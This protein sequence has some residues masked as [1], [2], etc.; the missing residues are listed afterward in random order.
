MIQSEHLKHDD[1]NRKSARASQ[2]QDDISVGS[3]QFYR[4]VFSLSISPQRFPRH[5]PNFSQL[6]QKVRV[7]QIE[8]LTP[9]TTNV[10]GTLVPINYK[11]VR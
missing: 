7:R 10:G 8:L 2:H 3:E 5:S 4:H 9:A 6:I 11:E 1:Q